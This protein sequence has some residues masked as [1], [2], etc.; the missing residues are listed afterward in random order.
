MKQTEKHKKKKGN[1]EK[2]IRIKKKNTK[3]TKEI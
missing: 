3:L 1:V 2:E